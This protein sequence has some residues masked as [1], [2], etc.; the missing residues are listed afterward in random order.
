MAWKHS[1]T[2][3]RLAAEVQG[4]DPGTGS[5]Y[6]HQLASLFAAAMNEWENS[7]A[8]LQTTISALCACSQPGKKKMLPALLLAPGVSE[9]RHQL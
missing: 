4:T 6:V 1:Q 5:S 7:T 2:F 9:E 3:P 8:A